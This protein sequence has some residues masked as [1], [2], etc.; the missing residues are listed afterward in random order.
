MLT[1][2]GG[3]RES[4]DF[5]YT[6]YT[7]SLSVILVVMAVLLENSGLMKAGPR[8]AEFE[9]VQDKTYKFSDVH[10][11]D[12]AK[13]VIT[14]DSNFCQGWLT[15]VPYSGIARGRRILEKS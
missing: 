1:A 3:F 14:T 13:N 15:Y 6:I 5:A 4:K 10:G 11:V 9:P 8:Q 7:H 2:V 12:E